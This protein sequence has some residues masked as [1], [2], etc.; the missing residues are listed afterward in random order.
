MEEFLGWKKAL[1]PEWSIDSKLGSG[2]FGHVYK[3]KRTD[4]GGTYYAALKVI[5]IPADDDEERTMLATED[6][7]HLTTNLQGFAQELSREFA[8]MERLKGHTN[9]VS[10]EDHKI[11]AKENGIGWYVLIRMELLT[12]MLEHLNQNGCPESEIIKLGCD[13]CEALRVCQR[14]NIIHRDIKPANIFLSHYGSYKLGDFGIAL[15]AAPG[16]TERSARGTFP[17]MAPEVIQG[18]AY[19]NT[20]DTYALGLILY[21]LLNHGRAPF[22]PLPPEPLTT[23]AV[24]TANRLRLAGQ[25]LPPPDKGSLALKSAVLKACAFD[26]RQRYRSAQDMKQALERCLAGNTVTG[27]V[28]VRPVPQTPERYPHRMPAAAGATPPVTP[29]YSPEPRPVRDDKA[30]EKE[31]MGKIFSAVGD[32]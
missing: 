1:W 27:T 12:P 31:K 9:I 13:I 25:R 10:Y 18:R 20:I 4:I 14:E 17:Y 2:S 23:A 21:R 28:A 22:Q 29:A 5:S 6:P 11:V 15:H 8:V 24:E 16:W 3:I 26:P 7:S 32:L 30:L 19:D